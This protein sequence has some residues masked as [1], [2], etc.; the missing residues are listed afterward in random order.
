MTTKQKTSPPPAA[1][2][3]LRDVYYVLFRHKW[4][5]A[6]LVVLGG[7]CS[8][9]VYELWPFPYVSEAKLYVRYIQEN[10]APAELDGNKAVKSPDDRG[11]NILNTE[12]EI[13]A[14]LDPAKTVAKVLGP[15]RI[16]GQPLPSN[17]LSAY[18]AA[19]GEFILSHL[20]AEVPPKSDVILLHY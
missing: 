15:D 10:T 5:S 6:A 7:V 12:L 9:A 19:A 11:A 3:S 8:L 16:L 17:S 2:I 1:S 14:S 18:E 20:K 4:L 13:L